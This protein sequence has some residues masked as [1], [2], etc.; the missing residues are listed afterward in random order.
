MGKSIYK[1]CN[2]PFVK[3]CRTF[4]KCEAFNLKRKLRKERRRKRAEKRRKA[5]AQ[6]MKR[7]GCRCN[8]PS[9]S[10]FIQKCRRAGIVIDDINTTKACRHNVCRKFSGRK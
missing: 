7:R 3:N 2:K 10:S 9:K 4:K 6:G 1:M 5:R 8:S